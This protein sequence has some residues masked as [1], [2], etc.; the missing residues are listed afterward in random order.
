MPRM[1][2]G[3]PFLG[4]VLLIGTTLAAAAQQP[5]GAKLA[6]DVARKECLAKRGLRLTV[7]PEAIRSI[8]LT[9]DGRTDYIVNYDHVT[10]ERRP[11]IFCG[12][13]G[14]PL[15]IVVALP[16]GR[17]RE[18]FRQQ[19]LVHEVEPGSGARTIRFRLHGTYCGKTGPE[20]CFRHR[21][22]S[23]RPFRFRQP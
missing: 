10:C 11:E 9:G 5:A 22:I 8:D 2:R 7:G 19:V 12:T 16:N 4:C 17:F 14:C 21:Q 23:A 6:L 13:G 1:G 3:R 15:V 18:V 20:P